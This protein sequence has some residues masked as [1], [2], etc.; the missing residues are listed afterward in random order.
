MTGGE[1]M[2]RACELLFGN[3][4]L[5]AVLLAAAACLSVFLAGFAL[6][7]RASQGAIEFIL[8]MTAVAEWSTGYF[9]EL[10]APTLSAK[11]LAAQIEYLGIATLPVLWLLLAARYTARVD[12][13]RPVRV[14]LLM[15]LPAV[16][17][18]LAF[19][20]PLHGLLWSRTWMDA[21]VSPLVLHVV[22]GPM[23]WVFMIYAY[24]LLLL[25]T[26]LFIVSLVTSPPFYRSA[27]FAMIVAAAA[28]WIGN[29]LYLSGLNPS[30]GFDT[31]P[32]SFAVSGAAV[33][34]VLFR[35]RF[36]DLVPFARERVI[37]TMRDPVIVIDAA[38][39]IVDSNPAAGF[40]LRGSGAR[41]GAHVTSLLPDW[42]RIRVGLAESGGPLSD[43]LLG[44]A[45][46]P[47][48]FEIDVSDISDWRRGLSG[49]VVVLH[50][51]TERRLMEAVLRASEEKY[52]TLVESIDQVIFSLDLK[53]TFTY[54]SP[55]VEKLS[56]Y[57]TAEIV[58][59]PF[60][61]FVHPDDLA[62]VARNM[63]ALY[64]G[65]RTQNEFR[66]IDSNGAVL[67]VRTSSS[68]LVEHGTVTG[69]TGIMTDITEQRTLAEQL[70]Q[71]QKMEAVG[72]LAGGI[73]HDFNNLLTAIM[74]FAQMLLMDESLEGESRE[75]VS[76]IRKSIDRGAGLVRQL[77]AFSRKQVLQPRRF[78]LNEMIRG[79]EKML[80][81]LIGENVRLALDLGES[82]LAIRADPGQVELA[83]VNLAVNARD[84]MPD[85]GT[86]SIATSGAADG[87]VVL[88]ISDTG[89]GMD[90]KVKSHLFE[91]F[92]TTKASG[93][94][95]GLGLSTVYGI[96]K[97][98][99][100][101][102]SVES[103]PGAGT[104]VAISFPPA[105][106]E[107]PVPGDGF[108]REGL[109]GRESVLI[110]EEEPGL[111]RLAL[112]VLAGL[113]YKAESM[114]S[115]AAAAGLDL[116]G[117]DLLVTDTDLPEM[118]GKELAARLLTRCPDMRVLY[119]SGDDKAPEADGSRGHGDAVLRKP[120][121]PWSLA[122]S[123]RS[124]LD[125]R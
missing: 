69:L 79:T 97:Q 56:G 7:R 2:L 89:C 48:A 34:W 19:T 117:I 14:V 102:V 124:V 83:V 42:D 40:L 23:F 6:N 5:S 84:A 87:G 109:A 72:R 103:A 25:G 90:E 92:F 100:G 112:T 80:A 51:T 4:P 73:A 125:A 104:T 120:F 85:G 33:A 15:V 94:G 21:A 96:V 91:P 46:R 1:Q 115:G 75:W 122:R 121:S 58:G 116:A 68:P 98:S 119:L 22:H 95:T 8:C 12:L 9:F 24:L 18:G 49:H 32:F 35:H 10:I 3:Y 11:L 77:L 76:E 20:N 26:L 43:F 30:P 54:V 118:S 108:S 36:L 67:Y 93:S 55:V 99:G 41:I 16:T 105:S 50:E 78:D 52:R 61:R 64:R 47:R 62:L 110:V 39:R 66:V 101:S 57:T 74:G 13:A 107:P 53:G 38:D 28:P 106:Q 71:S 113:G 45:E 17:I 37:E 70:H 111:R 31:T 29:I 114:A 63:E 81:R 60:S 59:S 44:G 86:L 27:S 82:P 123:V 88:R 65:E